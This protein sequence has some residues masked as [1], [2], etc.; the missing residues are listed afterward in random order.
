LSGIESRLS[1]PRTDLPYATIG[2]SDALLAA[3]RR[4][5]DELQ[6]SHETVE[7][8]SG[9]MPGYISKILGS[10]LS[11]PPKRVQLYLACILIEALGLE[12]RLYENPQAMERLA[13][14]FEK[15]RLRKV[16]MPTAMRT[17]E[18]M[19]DFYRHI[20]GLAADARRRK[21]SPERRSELAR[22]AATARWK[23]K[24]G[25]QSQAGS[26]ANAKPMTAQSLS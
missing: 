16:Q 18:L 6:L 17:I 23:D 15:R 21:I 2:H 11:P 10:P 9:A 8:I 24:T 14:R 19:P 1:A 4:R 7:A 5:I 20:S 12:I 26:R 22:H 13:R 25:R 3:I